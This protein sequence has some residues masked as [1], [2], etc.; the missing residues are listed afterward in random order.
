MD[1]VQKVPKV[2]LFDVVRDNLDLMWKGLDSLDPMDSEVLSAS[3]FKL[4]DMLDQWGQAELD[5][6]AHL[7]ATREFLCLVQS[8]F[9]DFSKKKEQRQT[10]NC[11]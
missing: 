4:E 9:S 5:Y 2:R 1:H 11:A 7:K 6:S 10:A 3:L 8:Q